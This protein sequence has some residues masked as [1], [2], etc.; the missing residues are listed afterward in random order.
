[1]FLISGGVSACIYL[2]D[3]IFVIRKGINNDQKSRSLRKELKNG[4]V[5]LVKSPLKL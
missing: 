1:L 5:Y 2:N 3:L 4:P